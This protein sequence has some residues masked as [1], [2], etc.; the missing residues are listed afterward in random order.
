VEAAIDMAKWLAPALVALALVVAAGIGAGVWALGGGGGSC[1]RAL[2]EAVLRDEIAQADRAQQPQFDIARPPHCG[3]D[4]VAGVV[5]EVTRQ[6]HMMPGGV[7]M[8]EA[9]HSTPSP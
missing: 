2:L 9:S 4:D 7:M 6:W 5:P 8:R 3:E 1:D